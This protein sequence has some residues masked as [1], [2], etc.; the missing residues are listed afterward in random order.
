MPNLPVGPN[1]PRKGTYDKMNKR[2]RK[3]K[4]NGKSKSKAKK[5]MMIQTTQRNLGL[6]SSNSAQSG[7]FVELDKLL[8]QTNSKLYRQGMNYHGRVQ[9]NHQQAKID[10][11]YSIYVLPKDHRTIGALKMARSIYNQAMQDELEIRPE[12]KSPWTDFKIETYGPAQEAGADDMFINAAYAFQASYGADEIFDYV[13]LISN[14][15]GPSEITSNAGEQRRFSLMDPTGTAHWNVFTEYT[16][17]LQNRADP[18]SAVEL[19][20]YG[21]ASPVLTEMAELADKGDEPPYEWGW[22]LRSSTGATVAHRLT[23]E[24]AGTISPDDSPQ[25][26]KEVFFEAP[27]GL[28]FIKASHALSQTEPELMIQLTKGNYKGVKADRLYPKDKLLGF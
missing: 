26:F 21:D 4:R 12:V 19:P 8:S 7:M 2:F 28:V 17:Y 13:T 6:V 14:S 5:P 22:Q 15:Y 25:G 1:T 20:A 11:S 27:L 23:L 18:D 10:R 16:N 24:L 3:T 9:L